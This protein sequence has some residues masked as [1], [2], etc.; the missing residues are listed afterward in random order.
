MGSDTVG[1]AAF[2]LLFVGT[3]YLM[4]LIFKPFLPGFAWAVVLAVAFHPLYLRLVARFRGRAWAA[5]GVL[6]TAVA[7][8]VVVP[9]VLAVVK[10]GQ[11]VAKG[12]AWLAA[13]QDTGEG[14][15]TNIA[16]L[17]WVVTLQEKLGRY[18][19]LSQVD[20]RETAMSTLQGL[21]NL[22]LGQTRTFVA[23]AIG[24]LVTVFVALVTMTALFHE[25]SRLLKF[26]RR[27]LPLDAKDQDAMFRELT[28]AT[29]AVFFGALATAL[30]QGVLGGIGW[31][32][33]G[34]PSAL[35]FG[36]AMFFCALLPVGTVI[37]WGPGVV[38]LFVDGHPW[39]ALILLVWGAAVVSTVDNLVRPYLVGKG[40]KLHKL[41]VFFGILGGIVTFGL[42]GVFLGPI[43]I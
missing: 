20:L 14:F 25:G 29:R 5:A 27:L 30:L 2:L 1:R 8:F 33:V 17:P 24:T 31:A 21:G 37:I 4:Y 15:L 6:A 13:Q 3:T 7:A 11:G 9:C 28:A 42:V 40:V 23:G 41:L 18:I 39:K 22:L 10:V 38:W 19:D 16:S 26:T 12:Y 35:T 43:V 36:A 34:L 32:I